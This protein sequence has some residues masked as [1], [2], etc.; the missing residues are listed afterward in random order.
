MQQRYLITGGSG[1]LGIYWANILIKQGHKVTLLLNKKK[2]YPKNIKTIYITKGFSFNDFF[3]KKT[4]DIIINTASLTNVDLCEKKPN[5]AKNIHENFV[6]NLSNAS[7]KYKIYLIHIS[8]DHLFS[9]NKGFYKEID[10]TKPLN[11]YAKTK[12]ESEKI[13]KKKLKQY[14]IIRGNF[15]GWA[16]T[17]KK[18]FSDWIISSIVKRKKIHVFEDVK[19]TPLY[20]LNF[21]KISNMLINK[22]LVGLYNVCSSEKISKYRFAKIIVKIFKLNENLIKKSSIRLSNLTQRPL[23]MSLSFNKTSKKLQLNPLQFS[24]LKQIKNL[25]LDQH[26]NLIKKIRNIK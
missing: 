11:I 23:D 22:R 4:F 15:F 24:V 21:I 10:R 5:L 1:F 7:K 8:T 6:E 16:P 20:V 3:K 19:F 9:G 13:I 12:L 18:S 14:L 2:I 17:Y 26:K 25:K